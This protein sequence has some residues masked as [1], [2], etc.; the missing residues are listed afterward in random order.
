MRLRSQA[1]PHGAQKL[2]DA[3]LYL[4][5]STNINPLHP[6]GTPEISSCDLMLQQHEIAGFDISDEI[7]RGNSHDIPGS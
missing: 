4:S 3:A 7:S 2:L 6:A 5:I 1:T